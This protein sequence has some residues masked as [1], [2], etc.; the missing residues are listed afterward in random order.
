MFKKALFQIH[1]YLGLTLGLVLILTGVTGGILSFEHEILHALNRDVVAAAAPGTPRLEPPELLARVR[2]AN[3]DRVFTGVAVS[4]EADE[5]AR[6]FLAPQANR[7]GGGRAAG[8]PPGRGE[9]WM[10]DPHD[11]HRIQ[12]QLVGQGFFRAV[13]G[14]HRWLMQE[15][16]ARDVARQVVAVST[17]ACLFFAISGIYLRWPK[18]PLDVKVWLALDWR[19]KG[20]ALLHHL[21]LVI[22]TW[23][24]IPFIIMCVTG[25]TWSYPSFRD[26]LT[27]LSGAPRMMAPGMAPQAR[28]PANAAPEI[29]LAAAWTV[30]RPEIGDFDTV[31]IRLPAGGGQPIRVQYRDKDAA[32]ERATNGFAL[33]PAT[34]AISD[35][36]RFAELPLAQR[37]TGSF[38]ALHSGAY[39]G[40]TGV[41]VFMVASLAMPLFTITGWILYLARRRRNAE[42]AARVA[43]A[44]TTR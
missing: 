13:T 30:I 42:K 10:V 40:V 14:L 12:V 35:H 9:T 22:G 31:T 15:G 37:L 2:A 6:V 41:V 4:A 19:R 11:G 36:R 23:V 17:I 3:P 29:D 18:R 39:F 26:L 20:K 24:A 21:H 32:H 8:G 25:L 1:L 16:P 28:G 7:D 34:M 27:D 33:D 44:T 5:P 43:A 38:F